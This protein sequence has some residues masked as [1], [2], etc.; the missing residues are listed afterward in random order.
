MKVKTINAVI[1]KKFDEWAGS[2][3]DD[4]VRELVKKNSILTGG[5]IASML[6]CEAVNDFDFY[7]KDFETTKAVANYYVE[8]F[9]INPP[10]SFADKT[11]HPKGV[12]IFVEEIDPPVPECKEGKRVRI[13]VKSSGAANEVDPN[14]YAY[15]ESRPPEAAGEYAE[16]VLSVKK[17]KE[18]KPDYRP[19]FLS[20][21]AI[22]L[23]G[24]VQLV[25][26]FYGTPEQIH[27]NYDYVH[28][29]NF[30]TS[31]D[32]K[33]TLQ[34]DALECLLTKELR[35]IGSKYPICSLIRARKFIQ[36][37][38]TIN[39]GQY[40]KIAMQISELDLT[41]FDVFREQLV[42]MDVA[43]FMQVMEL[44]KEKDPTKINA[45]YLVEIID[46]IFG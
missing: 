28:A 21:N 20:D 34:V 45:A 8:R 22:S 32:R 19:V 33:V 11:A 13:V 42:G 38:W 10:P 15:F 25:I 27:D 30:W 5:S 23:S 31:W 36:R 9:K 16:K 3:T 26:R 7:F 6:L 46:R 40:L 4:E 43:Y 39:A 1:N 29:T 24:D 18:E 37:E 35:Y 12:E 41:D 14:S 44:L 2:I 17:D